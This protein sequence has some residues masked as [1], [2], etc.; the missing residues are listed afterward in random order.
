MSEFGMER[1]TATYLVVVYV[2]FKE[3]HN[4]TAMSLLKHG[5]GP[6]QHIYNS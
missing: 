5:L 4:L 6:N 1:K 2:D 3:M